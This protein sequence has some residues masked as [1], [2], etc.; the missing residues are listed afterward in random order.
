M[1]SKWRTC[2]ILASISNRK[3]QCTRS[4]PMKRKA[5]QRLNVSLLRARQVAKKTFRSKRMMC[6]L[7]MTSLQVAIPYIPRSSIK[8]RRFM[9]TTLNKGQA[10]KISRRWRIKR[11]D[12]PISKSITSTRKSTQMVHH[13]LS[14]KQTII[15]LHIQ[16]I[17]WTSLSMHPLVQVSHS[18]PRIPSLLPLNVDKQCMFQNQKFNQNK[19]L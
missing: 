3:N 14:N 18:K 1:E 6:I 15:K 9:T 8:F 17:S 2:S 13:T 5:K 12:L 7:D 19:I 4:I 10:S 11:M 16:L